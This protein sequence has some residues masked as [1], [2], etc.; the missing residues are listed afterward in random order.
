MPDFRILIVEDID[1]MRLLLRQLLDG[2]TLRLAEG[3]MPTVK[4]S[5]VAR[6]IWEARG[7]LRARRPDLVLL[8]EILPGEASLDFVAELKGEGVPCVLLTSMS[9][10]VHPVP[11]GAL[12]RL[13]KPGER[14]HRDDQKHL[15]ETLARLLAPVPGA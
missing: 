14:G 2:A 9:E 3:L 6:N 5:G 13:Q 10:R 1:S 8:D 15:L 4:I 7:E 11:A 12:G